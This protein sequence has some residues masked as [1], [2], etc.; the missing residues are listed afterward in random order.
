MSWR[1][2]KPFATSKYYGKYNVRHTWIQQCSAILTH[3][4][5]AL[6]AGIGE[7]FFMCSLMLCSLHGWTKVAML[8]RVVVSTPN[9][10]RTFG[11][12]NCRHLRHSRSSFWSTVTR[13]LAGHI[14]GPFHWPLEGGR[15]FRLQVSPDNESVVISR[16]PSHLC[17]FQ[18]I[19]GHFDHVWMGS[20]T[21]TL[22]LPWWTELLSGYGIGLICRG[23]QHKPAVCQIWMNLFP[24]MS[25]SRH[26]P[27]TSS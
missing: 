17:M 20:I 3:W 22:C 5:S 7:A 4:T 18:H 24:V 23:G 8:E 9:I 27:T 6:V 16:P 26:Y 14:I 2:F 10:S 15:C 25:M 11:W 1:Y 21:P 19:S 12:C 13:G